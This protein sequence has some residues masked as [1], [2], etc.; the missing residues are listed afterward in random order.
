[1]RL[2]VVSGRPAGV[3]VDGK[4]GS[5]RPR[6]CRCAIGD[7]DGEVAGCSFNCDV[8]V[9]GQVTGEVEGDVAPTQRE[10]HPRAICVGQLAQLKPGR[11]RDDGKRAHR[12]SVGF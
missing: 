12:T 6:P 11:A 7:V 3:G 2:A 10:L 5:S 4:E 1:M 8:E 9:L